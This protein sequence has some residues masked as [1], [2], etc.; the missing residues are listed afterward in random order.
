[1]GFLM[2]RTTARKRPTLVRKTR[3]RM[4]KETGVAFLEVAFIF[5][6]A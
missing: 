2:Q 3:M 4:G 6:V 1:M 5:I